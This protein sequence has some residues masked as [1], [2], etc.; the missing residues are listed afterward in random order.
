VVLS[1]ATQKN[2]NIDAQLQVLRCILIAPKM[3]LKIY[4]LYD[5]C[6]HKLVHFGP[7]LEYVYEV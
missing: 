7:L 1:D 3:V 4:F 2:R 5:F 6:A